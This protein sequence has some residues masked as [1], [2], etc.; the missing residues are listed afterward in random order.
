MIALVPV[1]IHRHG[2]S[3][4]GLGAIGAHWLTAVAVLILKRIVKPTKE[5]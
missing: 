1:E 4:D 2:V 3:F 5:S